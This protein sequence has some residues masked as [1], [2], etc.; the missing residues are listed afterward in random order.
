MANMRGCANAHKVYE[1]AD[2]RDDSRFVAVG[3]GDGLPNDLVAWI[4]VLA[5]EGVEAR[6]VPGV[7]PASFLGAVAARWIVRQRRADLGEQ[8]VN[9]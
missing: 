7:L 4:E 1:Y 9:Q 2:P 3:V 6:P 5:A 8:S